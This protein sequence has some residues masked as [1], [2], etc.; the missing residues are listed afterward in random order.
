[1]KKV[2]FFL[3]VLNLLI[4]CQESF[5]RKKTH[6]K[7]RIENHSYS[8]P[9]GVQ[10]KHL[11]LSLKVDFQNQS[12]NGVVRHTIVNNTGED[13]FVVDTKDLT[14][15]KVTKGS[16]K[17]VEVDYEIGK[18][19]SI[20]GQ[21]LMIEVSADDNQINIYYKTKLGS[22]ALGWLDS[23]QTMTGKPFLYTQGEAI[24]TR[25]WIPLQDVPS[26]RITFNAQIDVPSDLLPVMSATNPVAKNS[27]G[28]YNFKMD[29]PI[30]SY[31]IAL[32]V[33]DLSF[34]KIN[35]YAGVY[36]ETPWIN[37]V[38]NELSDITK[39]MRV[40]ERLCGKYEWKR[41]DVVVLPYSFPFGGMENPRITFLNPTVIVGDKSLI[42]VMA[43]ELAHSWSGNLVT[44]KTWEDF[45]LNEGLTVYIEHRIME[46]LNDRE[47]ADMLSVIEWHEYISEKEYYTAQNKSNI[48]SLK[49]DLKGKN[50]DDGMTSVP[51]VRGAFMFKTIEEKIGRKKFDQVLKKYFTKFK[52]QSISTDQ[53]LIF[54][55]NEVKNIDALINLDEWIYGTN[56]P[57][58]MYQAITSKMTEMESL[59]VQV[60]KDTRLKNKVKF[61]EKWITL[62][63]ST[64]NTQEWMHFL[65]SMPRTISNKN[66]MLLDEFID[67]NSWNNAEIQTEWFLLAL[68]MNYKPAFE[69]L[70]A[71]LEK[72]GRRK[73]LQP[74]YV[75]LS[76]K[77]ENKNWALSVFEISKPSYHSVTRATIEDILK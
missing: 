63:R 8:N 11:D 40:A 37:D 45:W 42:S 72:V 47:Y 29:Q 51:Y 28:S 58:E 73:Y 18:G 6:T 12:I 17:E 70:Q 65:R 55:R 69:G 25:S 5:L 20:L 57:A 43:H 14:I 62:E 16:K 27:S 50:P 24:L 2:L 59:A 39:M 35:S 49:T 41:Y 22:E 71:F 66:M 61:Q 9:E 52:F 68:D 64:F 1:M 19:D 34:K 33:G 56:I 46:S 15:L 38:R 32:A 77:A 30:A 26:N 36:A 48:L 44:N 53:F 76:E 54:I 4:S 21:P 13:K 23:N 67:F 74:L 7:L 10:S 3:F 60:S 75:K 31:L